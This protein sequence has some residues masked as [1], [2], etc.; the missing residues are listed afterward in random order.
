M[1]IHLSCIYFFSGNIDLQLLKIVFL[2][3]AEVQKCLLPIKLLAICSTRGELSPHL[4]LK[5]AEQVRAAMFVF[6]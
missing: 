1:L 4:I 3:F 6:V 5:T 2:T